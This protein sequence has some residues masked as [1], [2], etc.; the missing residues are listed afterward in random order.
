MR[1]LPQW[2]WAAVGGSGFLVFGAAALLYGNDWWLSGIMT[3]AI[4]AWL[5]GLLA[6]IYTPAP[7]RAIVAGAL[8]ASFLYV[9]F[10]LGPWFNSAVGPWLLTTRALTT[11]E[12]QW[13]LRKPQS[14]VVYQV[15]PTY[16]SP[17]APGGFSGYGG[18]STVVYPMTVTTSGG[19]TSYPVTN[20]Y[21]PAAGGSTTFVLIGHWLCGALAAAAGGLAAAWISRRGRQ[22][23]SGG[24]NPFAE[25]AP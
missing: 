2:L 9:L 7:R 3:V 14:Q 13:L 15:V 25:A 6:A 12:T 10:A 11:I 24:E 8:A 22:P 21:V 19:W 20:S 18:G 23:T 1:Q 16:V 17:G 5:A 4:F